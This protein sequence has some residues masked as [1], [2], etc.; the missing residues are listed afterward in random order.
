LGLGRGGT[1]AAAERGAF[2]RGSVRESENAAFAE[3]GM[4]TRGFRMPK[5]VAL[6]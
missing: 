5:I 4:A 6:L 3:R 2:S 1:I